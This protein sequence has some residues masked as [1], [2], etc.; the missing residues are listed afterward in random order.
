MMFDSKKTNL[1]KR[2]KYIMTFLSLTSIVGALNILNSANNAS[3]TV[4]LNVRK[5]STGPGNPFYNY[6]LYFNGGG[7]GNF[8]N[9]LVKPPSKPESPIYTYFSSLGSSGGSP[10]KPK[11]KGVKFNNQVQVKLFKTDDS[12]IDKKTY[13]KPLKQ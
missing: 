7:S 5:T 3:A 12:G 4:R 8:D 9:V 6:Y 13:L 11:P 10:T 2:L 1:N